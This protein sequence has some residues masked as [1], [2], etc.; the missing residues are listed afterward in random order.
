MESAGIA[1][2]T[3]N[4]GNCLISIRF[5]KNIR[6]PTFKALTSVQKKEI[7]IVV[8]PP[9]LL[10][11]CNTVFLSESASNYLPIKL[12]VP[13]PGKQFFTPIIERII[14]KQAYY[15]AYTVT[16]PCF[17]VRFELAATL[18]ISYLFPLPIKCSIFR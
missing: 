18:L 12:T 16:P 3:G 5:Y 17:D 7:P 15:E 10:Q 2:P 1:I 8:C 13:Y 11:Y 9:Y 6:I 14:D 4:F